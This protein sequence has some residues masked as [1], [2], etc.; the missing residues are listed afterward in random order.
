MFIESNFVLRGP[1]C[2][3]L[4]IIVGKFCTSIMVFPLVITSRSSANA[5]NFVWPLYPKFSIEYSRTRVHSRTLEDNPSLPYLYS[6][7]ACSH[8][9]TFATEVTLYQIIPVP[10]ALKFSKCNQDAWPPCHFG[11]WLDIETYKYHSRPWWSRSNV[12][13][14]ISKVCGFKPDWGWWIFS[15]LKNPEHKS[16]GRVPSLRFQAR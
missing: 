12:L 4:K 5:I 13:V 1:V 11:S 3:F 9:C 15:G 7:N 8:G 14:S 16:S 2:D 6:G 10:R